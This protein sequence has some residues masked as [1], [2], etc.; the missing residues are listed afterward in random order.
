[1]SKPL[2]V[3]EDL[4]TNTRVISL[5]GELDLHSVDEL[6]VP[7]ERAAA[8][9]GLR[10]ILDL[11]ACSF[12]DSTGLATIVHVTRPLRDD[13]GGVALVCPAGDVRQLLK[14][15]ALDLSFPIYDRLDQA[16]EA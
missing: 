3:S 4:R 1:M 7:L 13:G 10:L 12:I 14:L 2:D 11:T 16:V 6:R 9:P 5:R 8:E 15:S